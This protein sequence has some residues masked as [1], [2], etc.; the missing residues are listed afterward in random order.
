[1]NPIYNFEGQVAGSDPY[2][3]TV[4]SPVRQIR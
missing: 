4:T 1:M 3:V 2:F